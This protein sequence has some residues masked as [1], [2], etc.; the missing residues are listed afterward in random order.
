M[1]SETKI[2]AE[3]C[4]GKVNIGNAKSF[5]NVVVPNYNDR[6]PIISTVYA[7]RLMHPKDLKPMSSQRICPT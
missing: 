2:A 5:N 6:E 3:R 1:V 4:V 7:L